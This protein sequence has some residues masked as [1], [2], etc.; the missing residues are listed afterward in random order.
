MAIASVRVPDDPT[1]GM[2]ALD[3]IKWSAVIR[4]HI[5]E[6]FEEREERN[7]AEAVATSERLSEVI[8]RDEFENLNTAERFREWRDRRSR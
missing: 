4:A 6:E 5:R 2:E 1:E 7:L 8:D 3:D